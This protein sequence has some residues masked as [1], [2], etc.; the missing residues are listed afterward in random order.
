MCDPLLESKVEYY[1]QSFVSSTHAHIYRHHVCAHTV[2]VLC[3][4]RLDGKEIIM[5]QVMGYFLAG[6]TVAAD[7][8]L[9]RNTHGVRPPTILN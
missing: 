9:L 5:Y 3:H 6:Q 4:Y 7:L 8:H 1:Y 2:H